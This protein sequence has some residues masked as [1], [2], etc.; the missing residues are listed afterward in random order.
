MTQQLTPQMTQPARP[1]STYMP[2]L[3]LLRI[4]AALVVLVEH[5]WNWMVLHGEDFAIGNAVDTVLV[6][7]FHLNSQL[8][9]VGVSVFL[10]ISGVVVTHVAFRETSGQF[11]MRR[12]TRLLP[13]FWVATAIAWILVT[14]GVLTA[15][16]PADA[17][18]LWLN[19]GL[20]N[21]LLPD[22]SSVLALTWTLAVQ[23]AFYLYIAATMPLLKRWPWV[24]PAISLALTTVLISVAPPQSENPGSFFRML[25][26]FLPLL[27]IGQL[28]SLVRS[29]RLPV[30]AGVAFGVL[31]FLMFVR[32][33]LTSDQWP[34]DVAF[35][36]TLAIMLLVLL[37]CS[38][39][40]GKL[41][42]SKWVG[43]ASRRTYAV[44]LL[45][46]P[47]GF[48]LL[49]LLTPVTGY[50]VSVAVALVALAVVTELMYRFVEMPFSQWYR[51]WEKARSARR[52]AVPAND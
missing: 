27:F 29:R 25:A 12:A 52:A 26:T 40:T 35:V 15:N 41:V 10:T 46:I 34:P 32:A 23:V 39:A 42:N 28:I 24:Q 19:L 20:L 43:E 22:V 44:Y 30:G 4:V 17:G 6:N 51:R 16:H 21:Y 1:R 13:A 14:T 50:W 47:V 5:Y 48:P 31:Q 8:V 37:L 36:R 2:G 45:H 38:R 18:D 7:P 49:G 11:L 33:D 3:D 9:F